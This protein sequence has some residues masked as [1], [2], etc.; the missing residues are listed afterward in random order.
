MWFPVRPSNRPLAWQ[1]IVDGKERKYG[2]RSLVTVNESGS[3]VQCA[4][5]GFGIVQAPGVI[6]DA[7]LASGALVEILRPFRP[8][9]RRVTILYPSQSHLSP[10]VDIF[11]EWLKARFP[12]LLPTWFEPISRVNV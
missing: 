10:V 2:P 8:R 5:S 1:F 7:H 11:V 4:L 3:Y 9:P 12:E 6:L